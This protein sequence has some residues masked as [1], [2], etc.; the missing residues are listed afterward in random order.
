MRRPQKINKLNCRKATRNIVRFLIGL[1]VII[2]I[3]STNALIS[4][5]HVFGVNSPNN[6]LR[7][8]NT[9]IRQEVSICI[10]GFCI[11]TPNIPD[12]I[13]APIEQSINSAVRDQLRSFLSSEIPITGTEHKLY[14]SISELPGGRF[15]PNVLYLSGFQSSQVIPPGDYEIPVHFYCTK[16]YTL[17]G[18]GNRF[19]LARLEGRLSN[20]LSALYQRASLNKVPIQDVQVLSWSM[21]SGI[22]YD[23]LSKESKNL[24]NRLIPDY[25][26]EL[27]GSFTDQT[28][29]FWN[30]LSATTRLPS[31]DE[32]LNQ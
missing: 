14:P 28:I 4:N 22:P 17:N 12:V 11:N 29:N 15:A 20:A 18:A 10:S 31:L 19:R 1:L 7:D 24:V 26:Q 3:S 8:F 16:V 27:N 2:G 21:Q 25:R 6:N 9:S 23:N 32:T 30:T 13:K 5:D